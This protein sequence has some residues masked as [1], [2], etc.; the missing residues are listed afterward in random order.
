MTTKTS[1]HTPGPWQLHPQTR[2]IIAD[3]FESG[4]SSASYAQIASII[5]D[6]HIQPV[7]Q[8]NARLIAAAPTMYAV[9]VNLK[10][11]LMAPDTSAETLKNMEAQVKNALALI[12][13]SR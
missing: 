10:V 5:G 1:N 3:Y 2:D 4:D 6:P 11:W 12:E 13:T 7:P 8:A 9:L